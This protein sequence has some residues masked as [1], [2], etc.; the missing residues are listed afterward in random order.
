MKATKKM[1]VP[2]DVDR[3]KVPSQAFKDLLQRTADQEC[4][5]IFNFL[6]VFCNLGLVVISWWFSG[7]FVL[8]EYEDKCVEL[9]TPGEL[10]LKRIKPRYWLDNEYAGKEVLEVGM[11][12]RLRWNARYD[13]CN[14]M[15]LAVNQDYS[16]IS[17]FFEQRTAENGM[18]EPNQ[19]VGAVVVGPRWRAA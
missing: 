14:T 7:S 12:L 16:E 1:E 5:K 15:I 8:L 17:P 13:R 18:V 9:L 11:Q 6:S 2:S 3:D 10:N 19:K 4:K